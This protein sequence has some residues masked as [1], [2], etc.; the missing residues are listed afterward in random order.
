MKNVTV[1]L[2][3]TNRSQLCSECI[4]PGHQDL[5]KYLIYKIIVLENLGDVDVFKSSF[6]I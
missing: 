6:W 1:S 3:H 4:A 5:N 2:N